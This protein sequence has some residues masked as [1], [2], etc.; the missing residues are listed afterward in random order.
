VSGG[1]EN[2]TDSR[3]QFK[4]VL[5]S[6]FKEGERI[7]IK[8]IKPGWV[9]NSPVDGE[10]NL[11]SLVRSSSGLRLQDIQT[12][13][14]TIV[15]L[16]SKALW[17]HDRIEKYI[18]KLSDEIA[19]VKQDGDK[20]KPIDFAYY[21]SEWANQ[22][23]FTRDQVREQ[24]DQWAESV[25]GSEDYKTLGLR[26]F[27]LKNFALAAENFDR[28]GRQSEEKVRRTEQQLSKDKLDAYQNWKL[29]GNSLSNLYRFREA[30]ERYGR[31]QEHVSKDKNPEKWAEIKALTGDTR[32]ELGSRVE[33]EEG[34]RL[35][36]ESLDEYHQ[37][38]TVYIRDQF[39]QQWAMTQN[40][41]GITL[42][43]LGERLSGVEGVKY[44][45][46]AEVA[47]RAALE[48]HTREQL[49]QHWAM[50][51]N[52]LGNVLIRLGERLSGA[53]G[54]KCLNDAVTAYSAALEVHTRHQLPQEW[55]TTQNN[56]GIVLRRLGERVSGAEGVKHLNDAVAAFRAALEVHTRHQLPQEW[57]MTQNSFANA[58]GSLG[59]RVSGAEGVKYLKD[60]EE[61]LRAA[62]EV[63]TRHQLPQQWA[64]TQ[65]SLGS[66]LKSLGDRVSGAEGVKY[67]KDAAAAFRVALEVYTRNQLPQQWAMTQNNLGTALSDLG[68][69]LSGAEAVKYL[70]DAVAAF[71]AALEVHTRDQLPQLWATT[72]NNLGTALSDLGE[73]LS[74]AERVKYLNDAVA[75][76]SAALEV[77]TR[78][79][80]PQQWAMTQNNL[81]DAYFALQNWAAAAE[82]YAEVLTIYPDYDDAYLKASFL[83]H[84]V[85]VKYREAYQLN[86]QWLVRHPHD[87]SEQVYF[88]V[89]HFTTGRFSECAQRITSLLA[90]PEVEAN[91]KAGLRAV[92]IAT[93]LALREG[94]LIPARLDALIESFGDQSAGFRLTWSF[95]GILH[96]I[97]QETVMTS[98]RD[99]L[100][101]LFGALQEENREAIVRALRQVRTNF[102]G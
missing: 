59:E 83:Y 68:E 47:F 18:A 45:R 92:E 33:G 69:R 21:L 26:A 37:V 72:Q 41:L 16:G 87:L 75:A 101:Q 36:L 9:V 82:A 64:M 2:E 4:I 60:A 19:K 76:L 55:A 84:E 54:I 28:A 40:N 79:Q 56:L 7:I 17:T 53:E 30:L 42:G 51:Q 3:G 86:Q 58:L 102:K 14:V 74:G 6:D 100:H 31:A 78:D 89:K 35:L 5:S 71:R 97:G 62:L 46:D 44:L 95:A 65:I 13:A 93:L 90:N 73:R 57:A 11:P 66:G 22:F 27:Y 12:L 77:Y 63:S 43:R 20:P 50:T 88:A 23:S 61:A 32:G 38:L 85:L 70:N 94:S 34:P 39:S 99:W 49:P 81:A 52:N 29:A 10:W 91:M 1:P 98:H 25:K 15:P 48:V 24:F 8:V 96:F 67:L 80:L